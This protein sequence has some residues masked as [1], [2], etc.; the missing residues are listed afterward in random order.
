MS[1]DQDLE[2]HDMQ[3]TDEMKDDAEQE[4]LTDEEFQKIIENF[5]TAIK[6]IKDG[7]YSEDATKFLDNFFTN[8]STLVDRVSLEQ[9]YIL[10]E[11]NK[12]LLDLVSDFQSTGDAN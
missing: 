3:N 1:D 8:L 4:T 6:Y 5:D 7:M 11:K 9:S 12:E 10:Q 2:E